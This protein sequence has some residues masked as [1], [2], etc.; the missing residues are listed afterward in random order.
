MKQGSQQLLDTLKEHEATP[1]R[2]TVPTHTWAGDIIMD[3]EGREH[4]TPPQTCLWM[5]W[6]MATSLQNGD[7]RGTRVH[8]LHPR[9]GLGGGVTTEP[10]KQPFAPEILDFLHPVHQ[11]VIYPMAQHTGAAKDFTCR[12]KGNGWKRWC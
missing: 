4:H 5:L 3:A 8:L 2:Q 9:R 12:E 6:C 10:I 7:L 1:E 11:A